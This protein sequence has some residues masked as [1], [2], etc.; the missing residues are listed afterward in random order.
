MTEHKH[1]QKEMEEIAAAHNMTVAELQAHMAEHENM[2]FGE[3]H[4][5]LLKK[6]FTDEELAIMAKDHNM[7]LEQMKSHIEM[8]KQHHHQ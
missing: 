6:D 4:K 3:T 7:T 1:S 8:A 5:V 2:A